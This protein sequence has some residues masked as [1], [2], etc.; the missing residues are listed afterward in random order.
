MKKIFLLCSLGVMMTLVACNKE[1][2]PIDDF[3]GNWTAE[4][5]LTVGSTTTTRDYNFTVA[6]GDDDSQLRFSGFA[7]I[8]G[9]A[10]EANRTDRNFTIPAFDI[11]VTVDGMEEDGT[12]SGSGSVDENTMTYTYTL[13]T[14]SFSQ[15][16]TGTATK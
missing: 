16:W 8:S 10:L 4:D 5:K 7:E 1:T 12:F 2:D 6:R 9:S 3:V 11:T 15:T 14:S 13:Q